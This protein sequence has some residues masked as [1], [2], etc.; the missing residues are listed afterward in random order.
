MR[1]WR[2]W[3]T[4][5]TPSLVTTIRSVFWSHYCTRRSFGIRSI[6]AAIITKLSYFGAV[7]ATAVTLQCLSALSSC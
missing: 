7:R 5:R 1:F 3:C 2:F 6:S 4:L